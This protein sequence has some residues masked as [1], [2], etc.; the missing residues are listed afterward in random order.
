[1]RSEIVK[2]NESG[3]VEMHRFASV[4]LNRLYMGFVVDPP[5]NAK[6]DLDNDT[7]GKAAQAINST[8]ASM[9]QQ[10]P[11][12]TGS[13][14]TPLG[15]AWTTDFDPGHGLTGHVETYVRN[16]HTYS[17]LAVVPTSMLTEVEVKGFFDSVALPAK[18]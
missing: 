10:V 2:G 3:S 7:T 9:L 5:P 13:R 18:K 17:V 6:L 12:K 1:V 14:E 4:F 8:I 15:K 16:N 11:A